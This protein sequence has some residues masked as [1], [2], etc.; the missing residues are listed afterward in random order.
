M[1][2][3]P[4][5]DP[6]AIR[7]V[8]MH[9]HGRPLVSCAWDPLGRFIWFGAENSAAPGHDDLLFRL[10]LPAGDAA[11][12]AVP[13]LG[14]HDSWVWALAVT[15]DGTTLVSGGY[16][17]RLCWFPTAADAPRAARVVAA[18]DGWV[19]GVR[20]SPDGCWVASCGNDRLV[21][22]W[23]IA[24]GSEAARL[25]GHES[26]VYQVA[27]RP[28]GAAVVSC[29]LKGVVKEW[30]PVAGVLRRDLATAAQLWTYDTTFRA[31]IGGARTMAFRDD[32][33]QLALGGMTKVT[34]AFAGVGQPLIVVLDRDGGEPRLVE[35]RNSGHGVTWG[36]AWHPA[37]FWIGLAGGG[38]GGWLRFFKP[39]A[40][41]DFHAFRLPANG[42]ALALA[43]DATRVAVA[44]AD[45]TLRVYALHG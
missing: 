28:D 44:L 21:R 15:P 41:D 18:H 38:G 8:L 6:T 33:S 25:E 34:N 5:I 31:D 32:G 9:R 24:D 1:P 40:T 42:R 14:G 20:V 12:V 27:W 23:N 36:V 30:D 29:D 43:A 17:G 16:D 11:A 7:E 45:G 10:A 19:R 22:I 35:S 2:A 26:H 37:G 4:V 13:C 3:T 39:D